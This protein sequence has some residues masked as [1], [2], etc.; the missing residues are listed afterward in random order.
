MARSRKFGE[1]AALEA[2]INRIWECNQE[3]TPFRS[4]MA[5]SSVDDR[6]RRHTFG[7]KRMPF[8][9]LLERYAQRFASARIA[10][11]EAALRP[12]EAVRAFVTETIEHSLDH[13]NRRGCMLVNLALELAPHDPEIGEAVA[14]CLD[15]IQAFF[16][17]AIAA[18]QADGSAPTERDAGDLARLLLGVLLGIHVL[19]PFKTGA[20]SARWLCSSDPRPARPPDPQ[21][22]CHAMIQFGQHAASH[23]R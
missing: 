21:T 11:L 19:A 8:G 9:K 14:N 15:D 20:H 16:F 22:R 1:E 3:T 4:L 5:Q 12:K 2:A 6:D 23:L 7:N 18:A 10:R 13:K 17:R